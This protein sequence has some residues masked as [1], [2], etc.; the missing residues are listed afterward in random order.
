[1]PRAEITLPTGAKVI[2]EGTD[3]DVRSFL[4]YY[5]GKTSERVVSNAKRTKNKRTAFGTSPVGPSNLIRGLIAEGFFKSTKRSLGVI[6]DKL[7]EQGHIYPQTTLSG[8]I[9]KLT[10]NRELRRMKEK[11][12]WV[13]VNT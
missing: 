6:Q 12:A 9:I 5:S 10:K 7:A 4:D 13:Y 8:V 11:G 3:A 1:M 2:I